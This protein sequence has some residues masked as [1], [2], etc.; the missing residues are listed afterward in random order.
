LVN[1]YTFT[2]NQIP[3]TNLSIQN[4]STKDNQN[5]NEKSHHQQQLLPLNVSQ[6]QEQKLVHIVVKKLV[7]EIIVM[8]SQKFFVE[9]AVN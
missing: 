6:L 8:V 9:N 1:K 7:Y 3:N 2:Y 5:Q 4:K